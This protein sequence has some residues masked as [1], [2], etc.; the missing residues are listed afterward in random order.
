MRG[1]PGSISQ[2][3]TLQALVWQDFKRRLWERD[4]GICGICREPVSQDQ[5]QVDH[6]VARSRG[7]THD[8]A[9]LQTAH[10]LC[11]IRK[12]D[13]PG[14]R[15]RRP[16]PVVVLNGKR[17]LTVSEAAE[18]LRV[19]EATVRRWIREGKLRATMLG[20]TKTGYRI[21]ESEIDRLLRGDT[22]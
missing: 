22:R 5:M 14:P 6:V 11:N 1:D 7:G 20:G 16:Q 18:Q 13:G 10:R 19:P 4:T 21:P 15:V 8:W 2:A 17:G 3:T 9:N 12:R